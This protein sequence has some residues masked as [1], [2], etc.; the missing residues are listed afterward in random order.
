MDELIRILHESGCSLALRSGAG[1]TR[2]FRRRGVADLYDLLKDEPELLRGAIIT[3]KV[4]GK[5]AAAL[6]ALGKVAR[7]HA[8]VISQGALE[9]LGEEGVE[10]AYGALVPNIIN[11]RGD[12]ICPVETLCKNC[13]T[14]EECYPLIKE[15]IEKMRSK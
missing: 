12:G 2:T 8:D 11:R 6:M 15:F 9:L 7:L 1:E 5:G 3:D 14:A 13:R 10:V 4:V